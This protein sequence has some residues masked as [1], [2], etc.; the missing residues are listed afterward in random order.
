MHG[1]FSLSTGNT[2]ISPGNVTSSGCLS[3]KIASTISGASSVSR[4]TRLT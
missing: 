2:S 4:S 3:S 1:L